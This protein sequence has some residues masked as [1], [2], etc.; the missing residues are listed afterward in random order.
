MATHEAYCH[1]EGLDKRL[2]GYNRARNS[3]VKNE[4]ESLREVQTCLPTFST[5]LH[6]ANGCLKW[7][8]VGSDCWVWKVTEIVRCRCGGR[9]FQTQFGH[10]TSTSVLVY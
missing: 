1:R 6:L 8:I 7:A 5:V 3:C 10:P 4:K 2:Y 9:G